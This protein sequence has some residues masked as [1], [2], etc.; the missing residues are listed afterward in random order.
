MW[1]APQSY[2]LVINPFPVNDDD[3]AITTTSRHVQHLVTVV[4]V[5]SAQSE[6]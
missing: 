5:T 3:L 6:Q 1:Y 4:D 2:S